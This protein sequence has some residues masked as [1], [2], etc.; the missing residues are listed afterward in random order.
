MKKIKVIFSLF[1]VIC[2]VAFSGCKNTKSSTNTNP[3]NQEQAQNNNLEKTLTISEVLELSYQKLNYAFTT[4]TFKEKTFASSDGKRHYNTFVSQSLKVF[5]EILKFENLKFDT[6]LTGKN[7]ET[8]Q[9]EEPTLNKVKYFYITSSNKDYITNITFVIVLTKT[10]YDTNPLNFVFIKFDLDYNTKTSE[11][12]CTTDIENSFSNAN[13][14]GYET[15][16]RA[17]YFHYYFNSKYSFYE[18]TF[19]HRTTKFDYNNINNI[20]LNSTIQNFSSMSFNFLN[21]SSSDNDLNIEVTI[22]QKKMLIQSMLLRF[23]DFND[24]YMLID[25][26][27]TVTDNLSEIVVPIVSTLVDLGNS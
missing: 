22:E 20:S 25:G 26:S 19:F 14:V 23:D 16:S 5:E 27:E 2:L 18:G 11:L 13:Y 9:S 1:L 15:K 10:N 7:L 6:V 17:D 3:E 4:Q 24:E 8:T 21:M 12:E